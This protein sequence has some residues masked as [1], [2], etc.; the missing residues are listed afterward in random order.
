MATWCVAFSWRVYFCWDHEIEK[1]WIYSLLR[2]SRGRKTCGI[3]NAFDENF[4]ALLTNLL[5]LFTTVRLSAFQKL[6]WGMKGDQSQRISGTFLE[7]THYLSAAKKW[8]GIFPRHHVHLC[9]TI[10]H[11]GGHV[12]TQRAWAMAST[13]ILKL[14][15]SS[16]GHIP[17]GYIFLLS[18]SQWW[19]TQILLASLGVNKL[20]KAFKY[21]VCIFIVC[22]KFL[23]FASHVTHRKI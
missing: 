9:G 7:T 19:G 6:Q 13:K 5:M 16:K 15:P 20:P 14:P 18:K 2:M 22:I 21:E 3:I 23:I 4:K 11:N 8:H 17:P 1:G 10:V 12:R